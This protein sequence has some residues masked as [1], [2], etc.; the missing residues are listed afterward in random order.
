MKLEYSHKVPAGKSIID[1]IRDAI[2]EEIMNGDNARAEGMAK[3]L[4][5][6]RSSSEAYELD[7]ALK[8]TGLE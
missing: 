6:L 3:A 1:K 2:D 5:I 7:L 8:R 4:G